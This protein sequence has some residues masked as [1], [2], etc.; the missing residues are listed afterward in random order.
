MS[1]YA[2]QVSFEKT[3]YAFAEQPGK[4]FQAR[5]KENVFAIVWN[6]LERLEITKIFFVFIV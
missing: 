5:L 4:L 2:L 1:F 3:F 6:W